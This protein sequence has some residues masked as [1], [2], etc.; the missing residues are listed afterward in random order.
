MRVCEKA[1][2]ELEFCEMRP[3]CRC[4]FLEIRTLTS[5]KAASCAQMA[6]LKAGS[7][8]VYYARCQGK[9]TPNPFIKSNLCDS[10]LS[11]IIRMEYH[12]CGGGGGVV[13]MICQQGGGVS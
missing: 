4:G 5:V 7:Y 3:V 12:H 11:S 10:D 6:S 9:N 13:V 8:L 1:T 2:N